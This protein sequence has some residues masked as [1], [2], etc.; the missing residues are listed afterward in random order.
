[1][2]KYSPWGLANAWAGNAGYDLMV[3]I[4]QHAGFS[5]GFH[6]NHRFLNN[7]AD[8]RRDNMALREDIH[9][10]RCMPWVY[11]QNKTETLETQQPVF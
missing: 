2:A 11:R 7:L 4:E 10:R 9:N 8:D 6:S 5:V 3:K 1:M